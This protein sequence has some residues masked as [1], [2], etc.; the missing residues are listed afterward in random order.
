MY[1]HIGSQR[2]RLPMHVQA[3]W[4]G[5]EGGVGGAGP[6]RM[7][8]WYS[9]GLGD[10][11]V[12][13]A[14]LFPLFWRAQVKL[15]FLDFIHLVLDLIL[16]P[17]YFISIK[18]WSWDWWSLMVDYLALFCGSDWSETC[19]NL[20]KLKRFSNSSL[21]HSSLSCVSNTKL[22]VRPTALLSLVKKGMWGRDD[23]TPNSGEWCGGIWIWPRA[24]YIRLSDLNR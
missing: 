7:K 19:Q 14:T 10:G 21:F 1:C 9:P 22:F 15:L 13:V 11:S 23:G 6:N 16:C 18:V 5:S 12:A 2:R 3:G 4:P 17:S 8:M 20:P 24:S